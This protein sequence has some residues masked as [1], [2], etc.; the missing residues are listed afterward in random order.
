MQVAGACRYSEPVG[1]L[2]S[3]IEHGRVFL[4]LAGARAET[5]GSGM[6][7]DAVRQH[8]G[9]V[10]IALL[11]PLI[12]LFLLVTAAEGELQVAGRDHLVA[13]I[14]SGADSVGPVRG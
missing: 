5:V 9:G 2:P 1:G 6:Q 4:A 13:E 10:S 14:E 3:Q 7:I 11:Y 8:A 12:Q